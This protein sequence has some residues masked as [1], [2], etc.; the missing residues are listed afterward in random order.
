MNVRHESLIARSLTLIKFLIREMRRHGS[1]GRRERTFGNLEMLLSRCCTNFT[2]RDRKFSGWNRARENYK[3]WLA[4]LC[5]EW[6]RTG[7]CCSGK[8]ARNE[9]LQNSHVIA[10]VTNIGITFNERRYF[11]HGEQEASAGA[12]D[13]DLREYP[14]SWFCADSCRFGTTWV[15]RD[16]YMIFAEG[17]LSDKYIR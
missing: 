11:M 12:R 4:N 7:V 1:L 9:R 17:L 3:E 6:R 10:I 15:P 14:N 2:I 13:D 5:A 16:W 8:S